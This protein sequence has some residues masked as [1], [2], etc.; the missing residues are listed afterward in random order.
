[1]PLNRG[2]GLSPTT[3]L[4]IPVNMV[5]GPFWQSNQSD[6]IGSMLLAISLNWFVLVSMRMATTPS[7]AEND[8][9]GLNEITSVNSSTPL[10]SMVPDAI[11]VQAPGAFHEL[12][13]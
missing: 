2:G 1:M 13:R 8:S 5:N 4:E 11:S 7:L 12:G 6:G 9:G 10:A 3:P